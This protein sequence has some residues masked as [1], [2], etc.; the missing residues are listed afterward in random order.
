MKILPLYVEKVADQ[1]YIGY[2]IVHYITHWK[3]H[4][5]CSMT[6]HFARIEELRDYI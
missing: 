6:D 2:S 1:S 3:R 5:V 4:V